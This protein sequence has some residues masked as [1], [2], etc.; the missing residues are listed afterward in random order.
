MPSSCNNADIVALLSIQENT[1]ASL[2][3]VFGAALPEMKTFW[4]NLV[5]QEK[6][7]GDV[8]GQLARL[9]EAQDV[10]LNKNKFNAAA[11]Q[12]NID[13]MNRERERVITE[14]ITAIRALSLA[15][16]IEHSL[17]EAGWFHII[18]SDIPAVRTELEE[19]EKHT[20]QHIAMVDGRLE[21]LR[22]HQ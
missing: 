6:A 7:H 10:Y 3:D 4:H 12:T 8:L 16:D 2:Y 9:C 15:A 1:I 13:S 5:V 19:I 22:T 18:E 21:K 11:V 17:I 14:G 20:K